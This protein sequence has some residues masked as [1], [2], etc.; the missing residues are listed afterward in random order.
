[1][2]SLL[3]QGFA[4]DQLPSIMDDIDDR[5]L[6]LDDRCTWRQ[7]RQPRL[8][9]DESDGSSVKCHPRCAK[10]LFAQRNP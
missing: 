9:H 10:Y 8:R 1:M 4:R 5:R 3:E 2:T 7:E 6:S